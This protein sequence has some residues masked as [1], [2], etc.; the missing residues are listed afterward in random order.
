MK[1]VLT[2][3]KDIIPKENV[4]VHLELE[5]AYNNATVQQVYRH[6]KD[7]FYQTLQFV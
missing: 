1:G 3:P 2:F 7:T 5:V 4:I 6:A